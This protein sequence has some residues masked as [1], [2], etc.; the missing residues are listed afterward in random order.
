MF[1]NFL[2]FLRCQF[3]GLLEDLF[4][5]ADLADIVKHEA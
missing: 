3:P 2:E 4:P 1:F 5:D